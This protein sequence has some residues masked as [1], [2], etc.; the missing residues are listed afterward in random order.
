[1]RTKE[2]A[3]A[4]RCSGY[5]V[6][7]LASELPTPVLRDR[8]GQRRFTEADLEALRLIMYPPPDRQNPKAGAQSKRTKERG[9]SSK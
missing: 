9:S 6:T 4:L 7:K 8:S 5:Q 1:M 2:I 3:Q